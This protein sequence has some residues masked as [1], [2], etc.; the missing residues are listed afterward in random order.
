VV[1]VPSPTR[2]DLHGAGQ[3][4]WN[5]M[6]GTPIHKLVFIINIK[7][8]HTTGWSTCNPSAFRFKVC[9]IEGTFFTSP[10]V[11]VVLLGGL[12]RFAWLTW[13]RESTLEGDQRIMFRKKLEYIEALLVGNV[14]GIANIIG[15]L[16]W[17]QAHEQP[18]VAISP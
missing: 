16:F 6:L 15:N 18:R 12:K 4:I 14:L 1:A 8:W 11:P 10:L 7:D 9:P 13:R 2:F 17:C 3:R 5:T